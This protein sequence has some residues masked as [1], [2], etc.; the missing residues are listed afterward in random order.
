VFIEPSDITPPTANAR[1]QIRAELPGRTVVRI[2]STCVDGE[3]PATAQLTLNGIAVDAGERVVL[4][5][6]TKDVGVVSTQPVRKFR[7]PG[8]V[9][10]ITCTD[11]AGNVATDTAR[12]VIPPL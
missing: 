12:I 6:G 10:R 3:G 7:A 9:L 4:I 1:F 8:F 2:A 11:A 5:A